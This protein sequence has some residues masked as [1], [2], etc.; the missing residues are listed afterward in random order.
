MTDRPSADLSA[1]LCQVD[2]TTV[3]PAS[4]LC[5]PPT[6]KPPWCWDFRADFAQEIPTPRGFAEGAGG[7]MALT[8]E[9][10][11]VRE[12]LAS[13]KRRVVFGSKRSS[14]SMPANPGR[15]ERLRKTT[16]WASATSR[17]GMP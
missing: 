5:L 16:C 12:S 14:F 4:L 2:P 17:I 11:F 7:Y 10:T 6:G 9:T 3:L 1:Q 8:A 13:P 15:M